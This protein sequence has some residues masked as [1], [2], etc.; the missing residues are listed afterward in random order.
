MSQR[1]WNIDSPLSLFIFS[2]IS[3]TIG[4]LITWYFLAGDPTGARTVENEGPGGSAVQAVDVVETSGASTGEDGNR[5]PADLSE[6]SIDRSRRNAIVIAAERVGKAVVSINVLQ[7]QF[8]QSSNPFFSDD[9]WNDFFFPRRY[10]REVQNLGSGFI[11]S[12]QGHILTNEHVV[13][14]AERITVILEDGREFQASILGSDGVSDLTILKIDAD[15]L[16]VSPMGTSRDLLIGE[17]VIAIGNPFGYLLDDTQPTVT[18]GVVSAVSR[19]IKLSMGEESIYADMIQ[20]DAS[21]NP[22]NSGGPLVNSRG[23]AVGVNTFIFTKSGGSLGIGFAIPIDRAKRVYQEILHY[24]KVL[25]PWVGIHPQDLTSSLRKGLNLEEDQSHEGVIV[26]DVDQL[27]PASRAGIKRGDVITHID[28]KAIRSAQDWAGI[29]LD[30]EVEDALSL[31]VFRDGKYSSVEF[32]T[33][34]LPTDIVEKVPVDF[35]VVLADISEAIRSQ[36]GLRSEHGA[37]IVEVTDPLLQRNNGLEPY[38]V[39]LKINDKDILSLEDAKKALGNLSK[40]RNSIVL[41]RNGR[42]IYRSLLIG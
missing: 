21:I 14:G 4:G 1:R 16:P 22:G 42:L 29:L 3:L 33:T 32:T 17:W 27:S 13:R 38:D 11:I 9:F 12:E 15:N 19:D 20:T 36:L 35:G 39:I 25:R 41:E 8:V 18:V 37:L 24:N 5:L 26:A 34:P 2:L 23:E 28:G 40:N 6:E 30:V 10:K 31:R 7:T